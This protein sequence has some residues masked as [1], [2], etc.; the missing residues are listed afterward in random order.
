MAAA[1]EAT[2]AGRAAAADRVGGLRDRL[3]DELL[4]GVPDTTETGWRARKI[5]SN[6]HLCFGGI[7]SEA[8]LLLLDDAGLCASAGSACTSGAMEPSHVLTAMGVPTTVALGS[9]RLSLG[10]ATTDDDVDLAAK[11]VPDAVARLRER[12]G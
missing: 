5:P 1:V 3:A 10:P 7:E 6:C 9:L 4:A 12:S 8:L 11:V 2:L